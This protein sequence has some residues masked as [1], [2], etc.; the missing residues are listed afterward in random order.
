M[1]LINPQLQKGVRSQELGARRSYSD[2]DS[3]PTEY[4]LLPK[5]GDFNPCSFSVPPNLQAIRQEKPKALCPVSPSFPV[6]SHLATQTKLNFSDK[7]SQEVSVNSPNMPDWLQVIIESFFEGVLIITEQGELVY[8][9]QIARQICQKLSQ[10]KLQSY[11]VPEQIWSACQYLIDSRELFPEQKI[12]IEDDLKVEPALTCH[13]RIKWLKLEESEL[14][15]L[16]VT[17]EN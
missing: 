8:A 10:Y 12:I 16:L 1:F 17:I 7:A 13:F 2:E 3:T 9:N 15:Y 14:P 4:K 11:C 5:A 6:N